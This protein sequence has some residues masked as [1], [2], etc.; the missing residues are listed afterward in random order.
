MT[1]WIA[2]RQPLSSVTPGL[3]QG[4]YEESSYEGTKQG[5]KNK[6]DLATSAA[7]YPTCQE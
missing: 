1:S 7:E 2:I 3:V 4:V 5:P 6:V